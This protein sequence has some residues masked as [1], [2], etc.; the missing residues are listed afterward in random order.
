MTDEVQP[1][2]APKVARGA[3]FDRGFEALCFGAATL[4]LAALAGVMVSLLIGG[5]PAFKAFGFGFFVS[6]EW[7]PVAEVYGA[8]GAIIGTAIGSM[9]D[10][11]I[12]KNPAPSTRA[13]L[14]NSGGRLAK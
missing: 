10:Q 6:A 9:I 3:V 2:T 14:N 11:N 4:L 8:L 7:D 1:G 12:W 5:W 13:A